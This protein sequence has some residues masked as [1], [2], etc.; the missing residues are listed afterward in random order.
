MP[1]WKPFGNVV[2][3]FLETF[4]KPFLGGGGGWKLAGNLFETFSKPF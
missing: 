2:G 3:S 4:S 1:I